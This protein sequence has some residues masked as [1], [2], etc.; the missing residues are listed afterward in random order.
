VVSQK[1]LV[2]RKPPVERRAHHS[3]DRISF[4][5]ARLASVMILSQAI[6]GGGIMRLPYLILLGCAAVGACA[7][8]QVPAGRTDTVP[9]ASSQETVPTRNS[10][11][12]EAA[13][14][15]IMNNVSVTVERDSSG[16]VLTSPRTELYLDGGKYRVR[17]HY[18]A[19]T[20]GRYRISGNSVCTQIEGEAIPVC[21]NLFYISPGVYRRT[22]AL[23]D[24][25]GFFDILSIIPLLDVKRGG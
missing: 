3:P 19:L 10:I 25:S 12:G 22:P 13:L 16:L 14:R 2:S 6:K 15:S 7:T 4:S 24:S 9:P 5:K 8:N 21:S 11:L 20:E 1:P 23:I 18:G 17:G